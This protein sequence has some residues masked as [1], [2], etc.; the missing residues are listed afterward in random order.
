MSLYNIPKQYLSA[1]CSLVMLLY[2]KSDLINI[3]LLKA[4]AAS[5]SG[6]LIYFISGPYYSNIRR[7]R[8]TLSVVNISNVR[9]LWS[10]YTF[11]WCTKI[12]VWKSFKVSTILKNSISIV[13]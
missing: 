2:Y 13:V 12:I 8:S 9:F 4:S 11:I 5:L 1:K 10:V 7:Q 6:P 3:S